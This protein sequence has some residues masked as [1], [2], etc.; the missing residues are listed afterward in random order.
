MFEATRRELSDCL[1]HIGQAIDC[2]DRWYHHLMRVLICKT[3]P[4][5]Q[6]TAEDAH[7]Q[8]RFGQWYYGEASSVLRGHPT[9][10]AMED[11]HKYLHEQAAGMLR[12][13]AAAGRVDVAAYDRFVEALEKLHLRMLSLRHEIESELY[14]LD[15]LTDAYTRHGMMTAL[16]EQQ[17]MV[18]RGAGS[19]AIAMLD[20]DHFKP[21][22]DRFGHKAGDRALAHI[23]SLLIGNLRPY[24]KLYRYGGEEFVI[25]LPNTTVQAAMM[26]TGRMRKLIGS[27]TIDMGDDPV[28]L[29]VSI[30]VAMIDADKSAE[31]AVDRADQ[32]MYAAKQHGRDQ[33]RLWEASL[34]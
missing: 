3:E 27:S 21:I 2:H 5:P 33:V 19:C 11:E 18:A 15:P 34:A 13:F 17:Q 10:V 7:A 8:C 23:A 6:D 12:G 16:R 29:T 30:G 28:K 14:N 24:D 22:N 25:M 31:T 26:I 20:V 4:E 9:F 1:V 32:A